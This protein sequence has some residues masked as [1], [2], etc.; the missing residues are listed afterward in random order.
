MD[1]Q[2][3]PSGDGEDEDRGLHCTYIF[4][5]TAE[6]A[7]PVRMLKRLQADQVFNIAAHRSGST[8]ST[9]PVAAARAMGGVSFDVFELRKGYSQRRHEI[10]LQES[11]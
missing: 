8:H 10:T 7:Q 2:R 4:C 5:S 6:N 3:S 1:L 11:R 9:K